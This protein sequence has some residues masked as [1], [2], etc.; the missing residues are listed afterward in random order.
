MEVHARELFLN[1]QPLSED[2]SGMCNNWFSQLVV[3][4]AGE[5]SAFYSERAG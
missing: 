2:L 1:E 5:G 4:E 3:I